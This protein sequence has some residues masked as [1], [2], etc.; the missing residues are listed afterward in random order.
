MIPSSAATIMA[1]IKLM[2]KGYWRLLQ[3]L[4]INR[5]EHTNRMIL[6]FTKLYA[7]R[8]LQ[9][10]RHS[11]QTDLKIYTWHGQKYRVKKRS[12]KYARGIYDPPMSKL[13][14]LQLSTF[15][16]DCKSSKRS[17]CYR[18]GYYWSL[19]CIIHFDALGTTWVSSR[20]YHKKYNS[21][22]ASQYHD[23]AI[24]NKNLN[25]LKQDFTN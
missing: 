12:W 8:F 9:R 17:F 23:G 6:E 10:A 11:R 2:F 22:T 5:Y 13:G 16:R 21:D 20:L 7:V 25:D 1:A 4:R 15:F 18:H 3:I 24:G 14:L 19:S